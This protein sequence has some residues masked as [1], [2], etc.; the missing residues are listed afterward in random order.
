MTQALDALHV[1]A[2]HE[3]LSRGEGIEH[4]GFQGAVKPVLVI[5]V[6]LRPFEKF[7]AVDPRTKFRGREEMGVH[8]VDL[9]RAGSGEPYW[10]SRLIDRATGR[11]LEKAP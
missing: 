3:V 4:A 1:D 10:W 2:H 9:A 7:P 11:C 6:D 8:A 5:A